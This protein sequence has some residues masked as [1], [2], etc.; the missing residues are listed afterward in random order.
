MNVESIGTPI[1][2]ILDENKKNGNQ[3]LSVEAK[4][5]AVVTYLTT[6][7]LKDKKSQK[8]QQ[9]PNPNTER[10]ILYVT[11]SSGSGK[12]YYTKAYCDCYRK[13][14]PKRDIFLFSSLS[15]DSSIDK[16]KGLKRIKITP[17]FL[18]E[19]ISAKDFEN[20]L[21]IFDDTD[22]ITQKAQKIKLQGIL[23]SVLET[24]RHFNTSVVYT[25][26]SACNGN[27]TKKILN[28]AHSITI[29]PTGLGG[30]SLKYL[31]DQYLGLDKEQI[32]KIKKLE[33]RWVTITKTYPMCVISEKECYIL[34]T[35]E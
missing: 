30:R 23:N 9:V 18:S 34:N 21:V 14:Y 1:A 20:S 17:E 26:H 13:I 2:L 33:S 22:C 11:G 3:V 31:L 10:N 29:F 4:K 15:D 6:L 8:F 25:S 19:D 27:D 5:D 24:G 28:E 16:I 7:D 35:K 12:S 32:K